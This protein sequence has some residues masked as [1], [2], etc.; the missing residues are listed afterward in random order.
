MNKIERNIHDYLPLNRKERFFT[1]TVLP[2]IIC[3]DNFKN[4]S[5]FFELIPDFPGGI[6]IRPDAYNNN[7]LFF[8]E[9]SL[10]E[11]LV[12]ENHK[13]KFNGNYDTKDTPDA[14][15]LITEP[16]I[17]LVVIEAKMYSNA[18]AEKINEQLRNQKWIIDELREIHSIS[19][20]N[21]FHIAITPAGMI[22][23]RSA[24]NE[25]LIYWE[26]IL[27]KYKDLLTNNYFYETLSIAISKFDNL[28]SQSGGLT[29]G[30]NM[31]E[32]ISGEVIVEL[33]KKGNKFIV[34]RGGGISGDQLRTD[35]QKGGWKSFEYEVNYSQ[36]IPVNRNWFTS[37]QFVKAVESMESAQ[38]AKA[39]EEVKKPGFFSKFFNAT[40][41]TSKIEKELQPRHSDPWHFSHLGEEYFKSIASMLR[42]G[43]IDDAP[44]N[45]V[46]IGKS[47][48]PYENKR[49]G[50]NVNPNWAVVL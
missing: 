27:H 8:T 12:E 49:L 40:T 25:P 42:A 9:Y 29:Y 33:H 23:H 41:V 4:L 34:G 36:T 2:Q 5:L 38:L 1:G 6:E 50:R 28:K 21:I 15:I 44:I 13:K 24:I 26:D 45:L 22:R 32:K 37:E 43:N 18:S 48:E 3:S 39:T 14:I 17:L 35:L 30:K 19:A 46:Y 20:E 10:K 7:I 31:D 16:Q 11:S 47:G